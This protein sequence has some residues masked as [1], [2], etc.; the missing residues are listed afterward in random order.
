MPS[1]NI[2]QFRHMRIFL[3]KKKVINSNK[4]N[5]TNFSLLSVLLLIFLSDLEDKRLS[6][7]EKKNRYVDLLID[8][9]N[10]DEAPFPF[11]HHYFYY[12]FICLNKIFQHT[13]T[14]FEAKCANKKI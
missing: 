10:N 8:R 5:V 7:S 6:I 4:S 11:L 3:K 1:E 14:L 9:L 2:R 13:H 12:L